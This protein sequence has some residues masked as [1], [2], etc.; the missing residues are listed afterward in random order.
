RGRALSGNG[1]FSLRGE[2]GE[3]ELALAL[4]QSRVRASG[5]V[6]NRID[7][8][9]QL[10]PLRI[11]DVLPDGAGEVQGSLQLTGTR[12]APDLEADVQARGVRWDEWSAGAVDL[13]G[14]LPWR[15][16]RGDLVLQGRELDVGIALRQ[17]DV[18]ARG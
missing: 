7:V 18:H 8:T 15:G 14:R 6:G 17:L 16:A 9:A 13:R 10:A 3:G 2:E 4:G 11:D 5:R 1:R 12:Q